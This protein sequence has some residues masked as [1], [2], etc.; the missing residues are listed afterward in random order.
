M[1]IA[2]GSSEAAVADLNPFPFPGFALQTRA[3]DYTIR[4]G[5]P[6]IEYPYIRQ[7][8]P[9]LSGQ[10]FSVTLANLAAVPAFVPSEDPEKAES[11]AAQM[12]AFERAIQG[13]SLLR[14]QYLRLALPYGA[15]VPATPSGNAALLLAA[16][17]NVGSSSVEVYL[18]W[19]K[20]LVGRD[21]GRFQR[22][23]RGNDANAIEAAL[24]G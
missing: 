19:P 11:E 2:L 20:V 3:V 22:I 4:D 13:R 16:H 1:L 9:S 5:A 21:W 23:V 7:H 24:C 12:A 15:V 10:V 18:H 6:V 8:W 17:R 14:Y